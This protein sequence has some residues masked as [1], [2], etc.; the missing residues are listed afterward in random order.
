MPHFKVQ[1]FLAEEDEKIIG[2]AGI[3]FRL[4]GASDYEE[5]KHI[6]PASIRVLKNHQRKGVG[7]LLLKEILDFI[8][9][10]EQLK[11]IMCSADEEEGIQF[12][13][14]VGA[15][16]VSVGYEN[17]LYMEK[18][19]WNLIESWRKEGPERA[20]EVTLKHYDEIPDDILDEYIEILEEA[21]NL[22]PLG[23]ISS[24]IKITRQDVQENRE[25]R[26]KLGEI[27]HTILTFEEN[28][29]ISGI[30]E[31]IYAKE[32]KHKLE[33]GITGVR[34]KYRGR[35]LGKW[36]KAEMMQIIKENY[37]DITFIATGNATENAPMLSI[38]N[39]M[40]FEPFRTGKTYELEI[41][42]IKF[43]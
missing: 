27:Q 11:I 33:Q 24:T 30:T 1:I 37:P 2:W 29:E 25:R 3:G 19:D 13:E 41:D 17:R 38:N 22:Q 18:V 4:E 34:P 6:F 36:M 42:K 14:K 7:T 5:N 15:K 40:G 21:L 10:Q 31:I 20:P 39:R 28:N 32:I 26:D 35:G 8:K 43:N 9:D 16:T 12:C 23:E